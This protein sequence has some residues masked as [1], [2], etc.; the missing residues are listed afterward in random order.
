MSALT[1]RAFLAPE[2]IQT[3]AMDC[4]PAAL[5]CLLA[6]F[7][8]SVSYGRLREAC[9][10]SVDG[11]SIDTLESLAQTLGLEAEQVML[12]VDHLLLAEA[13][14]LP[15][16]VVVRLPSGLT[17]FV[18]VWR[19][20]G[21]WV[22]VMDPARGRRWVRRAAFL[23]DVYR[24]RQLVPAEAVA[25]WVASDGFTRPLGRRL[26]ALGA[27]DPDA[28]VARAVAGGGWQPVAALDAAART[29]EGL[30]QS[31][32][33]ARGA[34]AAGLV[35]ALAA[36]PP[37]AS[38]P[39]YATVTD[40]SPA[41]DGT[42]QVA[43]HGAVLL[44]ASGAR[45][46][47]EP[48]RAELPI[49]LRAA[50]G[51]RPVRVARDLWRLA[52]A[53]GTGRLALLSAGLLLA[54]LGAV[55]EGLLF[56]S[57][58]DVAAGRAGW[59]ARA[60]GPA[61]AL[62]FGLIALLLGIEWP[63][64]RRLRRLGARV[65]IALRG[66]YLRKIPRLPDRYFQTR[67]VSDLAERAHLLHRLRALPA[68]AGDAARL[69]V[70]L[71]VIGGGLCVLDPAGA[72]WAL[73][74][75]AASLAIPLLAQPAVTE[76]DLRMR[77]H[78]G[79]LGRFYLDGLLGLVAARTHRAEAAL[80]RE[81]RDR[82]LEWRRAARDTLAA[83]L[84]AETAQSAIG[85]GLGAILVLR[86]LGRGA[87]AA[88]P[89]TVLLIVFWAL[90]LPALGQELSA[91]VQQFP[92]QRNLT[93]RLLEPLGAPEAPG[94]ADGDQRLD[95]T[96]GVAIEMSGVRA[97]AGGHEILA[98]DQLSIAP[99]EQVAIVG[100]SGAGK[101][102]LVGLLLGWHQAAAG[103]VRVDGAPLDGGRLQALRRCT[104]W[105]DPSV[106]LWNRSL[107]ANLT[108]GSDPGPVDLAALLDEADLG[109]LVGRLPDG[110]A[111]PLGEAG[112]LVSGGEGQRVRF[113]RALGRPSPRLVILD[114][115]FRG[116]PRDR[117][118]GL[119][120][121]ARRRW[122]GATLLCI[123]HDIAETAEFARV[124]VVADGG[125]VEDGS[126]A[127]LLARPGSRYAALAEAERRVRASIWSGGGWRRWRIA[128]GRV[129]E[130]GG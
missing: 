3:S 91:A 62:A 74:L 61:I 70:E 80:A 92:A 89:G 75:A 18:V 78:A 81:H 124:L 88:D 105:V 66:L 104:A 55:A 9:Q 67:P 14:A 28:I 85:F 127:A 121:R 51:E 11:T 17:H 12:P 30:A 48:A 1:R 69:T 26:R 101:S 54:A 111:T 98:V 96:G 97:V 126:P 53:G 43:V 113:G 108:F 63:L 94:A 84:A 35:S 41:E 7:G 36:A 2:V 31:G 118:G 116:L 5:K 58:I 93:L 60:A 29:V 34:E 32:A 38:G 87:G 128:G 37:E 16:I 64:A 46:L 125:V 23:R 59:L 120:A 42:P 13:D 95:G 79:A 68:L 4:G 52:R 6:G 57:I 24:H 123:T 10:T 107:A 33:V 47:D 21:P 110:P 50:V 112:G 19:V 106:Y 76:R 39:L 115:P 114:E 73:A 40:A 45:R 129:E 90:S 122:A 49:E 103:A 83:A 82:L 117:R 86:F 71:L 56:R 100:P 72:G 77:N 22:Q 119:M 109:E 102:T 65:E 20:H 130:G 8:V 99:G 27:A 15:A 25:E 44:R